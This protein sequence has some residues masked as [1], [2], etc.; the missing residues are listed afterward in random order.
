M[1]EVE[2]AK[3]NIEWTIPY[4]E[5]RTPMQ[6]DSH[7]EALRNLDAFEQ[8]VRAEAIAETEAKVRELAEERDH[9]GLWQHNI[10]AR[11]GGLVE[12]WER[13]ATNADDGTY[14][15]RT[16]FIVMQARECAGQLRSIITPCPKSRHD[17]GESEP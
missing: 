10:L 9:L 11:L 6:R 16:A 15:S 14:T 5:P 7:D 13:E 2:K 8:A 17:A 12:R 4:P 3:K 1:S